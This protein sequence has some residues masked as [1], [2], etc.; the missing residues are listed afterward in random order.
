MEH[1]RRRHRK[2]QVYRPLPADTLPP[3]WST[4]LRPNESVV[5]ITSVGPVVL[6]VL[7]DVPLIYIYAFSETS[8][9]GDSKTPT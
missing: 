4:F 8:R 6:L 9:F 2:G 1:G 7:M 5:D 3:C